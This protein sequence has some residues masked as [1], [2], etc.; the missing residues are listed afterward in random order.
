MSFLPLSS[1]SNCTW[2]TSIFSHGFQETCDSVTFYFMKN[3]FSDVSW[4]C[5]LPNMTGAVTISGKCILL[6]NI[7]RAGTSLFIHGKIPFLLISEKEFFHE[8]KRYGITSF[9]DFTKKKISFSERCSL[10]K[11]NAKLGYQIP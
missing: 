3:K 10:F 2:S 1:L 4:R 11:L 6:P 8:I 5:I 7:I 9:L